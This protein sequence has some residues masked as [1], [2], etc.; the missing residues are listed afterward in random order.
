MS[1]PHPARTRR[2]PR[3]ALTAAAGRGAHHD[4]PAAVEVN[5]P[6]MRHREPPQASA[7]AAAQLPAPPL[8]G[9][10]TPR[11]DRR[12]RCGVAAACV[13]L[14]AT[15]VVALPGAASAATAAKRAPRENLPA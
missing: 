5:P 11:S 6:Q 8:R 15:A 13:A 2:S 7:I 4:P 9:D 1:Y 3:Q 12:A 14:A 10:A